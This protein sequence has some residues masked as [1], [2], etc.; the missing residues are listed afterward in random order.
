MESGSLTYEAL[1]GQALKDWKATRKRF[2]MGDKCQFSKPT[3]THWSKKKF[4]M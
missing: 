4:I 2:G 3:T 1:S